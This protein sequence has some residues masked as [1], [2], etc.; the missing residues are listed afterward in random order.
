MI[1]NKD[2][3]MPLLSF[4][5]R[6]CR[7]LLL[8]IPA[9]L[10][11]APILIVAGAQEQPSSPGSAPAAG[12]GPAVPAQGGD[13]I[14][15][16]RCILCHNKQRDDDSPFGPPNLY[17]AFH[18]KTP[19]TTKAAET[20]IVNGKGQMPAFGAVLSKTEIHQVIAYLRTR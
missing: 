8:L 9:L 13:A 11:G 15:H 5:S 18:G 7:V 6:L 19:L 4:S 1:R 20:I 16:K 17:T 12:A 2:C 3:V 10:F 14:F